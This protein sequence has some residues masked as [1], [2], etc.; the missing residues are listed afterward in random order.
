MAGG[1][2]RVLRTV[3]VKEGLALVSIGWGFRNG[4]DG[5]EATNVWALVKRVQHPPGSVYPVVAR[6]RIARAGHVV[7]ARVP[8]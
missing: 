1:A 6:Q 7:A 5:R 4:H 2:I 8:L 3:E